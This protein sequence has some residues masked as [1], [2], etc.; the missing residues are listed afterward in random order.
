MIDRFGNL[1]SFA[2]TRFA[3]AKLY[4]KWSL[5][6]LLLVVHYCYSA[7]QLLL[8]LLPRLVSL[9]RASRLMTFAD[10]CADCCATDFRNLFSRCNTPAFRFTPICIPP[11]PKLDEYIL[12]LFSPF[13]QIVLNSLPVAAE[14]MFNFILFWSQ[15]TAPNRGVGSYR[16]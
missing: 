8:A 2:C 13:L 12:F 5:L 9:P 16:V 11:E 10:L 7:L 6:M 14:A 1:L 4:R 3:H 15:F